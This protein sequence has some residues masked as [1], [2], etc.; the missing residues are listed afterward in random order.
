MCDIREF[1]V[2]LFFGAAICGASELP[3]S[4]RQNSDAANVL[5]R[6]SVHLDSSGEARLSYPVASALLETD[7]FLGSLQAAYAATLPEGETPEF[8][9]RQIETGHY[10]YKNR[11]GENTDIVELHRVVSP[12]SANVVLLTKGERFFGSFEALTMIQI[13]PVAGDKVEWTVQVLAWPHN[14]FSR[15]IART[16]IVNR[17]FRSKTDDL[18]ALTVKIGTYMTEQAH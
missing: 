13:K 12:D 5:K 16:G 9:V 1:L 6:R 18:I 2:V 8:V 14:F 11:D 3:L 15:M 17:Y 4:V 10:A 7:D